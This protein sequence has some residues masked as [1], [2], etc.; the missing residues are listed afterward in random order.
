MTF[1]QKLASLDGMNHPASFSCSDARDPFH[2]GARRIF[3][4]AL[5]MCLALPLP[6]TTTISTA[7]SENLCDMPLYWESWLR[8][9]QMFGTPRRVITSIQSLPTAYF[10]GRV[11]ALCLALCG[12]MVRRWTASSRRSTGLGLK[13]QTMP[14]HN[15]MPSSSSARREI[16]LFA[17]T[18]PPFRVKT[19]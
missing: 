19:D 3:T 7:P 17:P 13:T 1:L 4:C 18:W 11:L 12:P 9:S 8:L 6:R 5:K 16:A 2:L 14:R 10:P 15:Q